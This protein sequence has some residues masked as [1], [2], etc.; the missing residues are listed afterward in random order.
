MHK[1][2]VRVNLLSR[3][4]KSV[5][6]LAQGLKMEHRKHKVY[7]GMDFE[8]IS[9]RIRNQY[10]FIFLVSII[11]KSKKMVKQNQTVG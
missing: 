6:I 3:L 8:E 1:D 4:K 9:L 11:S 5:Y 2:R 10:V 7:V